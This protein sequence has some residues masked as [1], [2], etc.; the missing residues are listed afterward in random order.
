M[1]DEFIVTVGFP[2]ETNLMFSLMNVRSNLLLV[3]LYLVTEHSGL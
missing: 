3:V 2:E 1:V